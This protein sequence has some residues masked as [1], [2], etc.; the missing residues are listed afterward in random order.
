MILEDKDF[1]RGQLCLHWLL[2]YRCRFCDSPGPTEAEN[3]DGEELDSHD[4]SP[5]VTRCVLSLQVGDVHSA[6]IFLVPVSLLVR[7]S[8]VNV[9]RVTRLFFSPD[10]L[11]SWL[12]NIARPH[13]MVHA[14]STLPP[15]PP[16][17]PFHLHSRAPT[18][19]TIYGPGRAVSSQWVRAIDAQPTNNEFCCFI[20]CQLVFGKLIAFHL[21]FVIKISKV[22]IYVKMM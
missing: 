1:P 20:K 3:V 16:S 12:R 5:L 18:P 14:I 6:R 2:P 9:V 7:T 17:K 22:W 19:Q 21:L 10:T 15:S 4:R 8:A 11:Y 13:I